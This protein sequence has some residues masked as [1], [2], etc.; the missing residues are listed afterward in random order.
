MVILYLSEKYLNN[1]NLI[2]HI[3]TIIKKIIN[4]FL[5]SI[6]EGNQE[7][8]PN[9]ADLAIAAIKNNIEKNN[10]IFSYI[11]GTNENIVVKFKSPNIKNIKNILIEYP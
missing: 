5:P 8:K 11:F 1:I 10:N 4:I 3:K 2:F 9:W 6:A 7:C